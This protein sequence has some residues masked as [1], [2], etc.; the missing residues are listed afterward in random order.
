MSVDPFES[1]RAKLFAIAYRM[2]GS[3]ADAD[4]LVS[5]CWLRWSSADRSGVDNVGG[6]LA[7]VIVRLSIDLQKSA[8]MRR[9]QYVGP[10]LPEPLETALDDDPASRTAMAESVSSAFLLV[11]E[12][13][14]PAERA[15]L[16]LHD[17]FEFE[18]EE[19]GAMI[20]RSPEA[21]RQSLS[22]ARARLRERKPRFAAS[23]EQHMAVL[24]AFSLAIAT[25]DLDSLLALLS[26]DAAVISDSNGK[27][28]AAR[29]VVT[30]AERCARL[31]VGLA[32][33]AP[34]AALSA[35]VRELNGWP[36]LVLTRDGRA[37]SVIAIE[38]DGDRVFA[39]HAMRNPDKLARL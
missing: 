7:T 31:L 29:N 4:E 27:A 34:T 14:S 30:G 24:S 23:T 15:V 22:R 38:T 8:R 1:H 13:L 39:V 25:G 16:V 3:R 33:K 18:H 19:I 28:R 21:C 17:V 20:D 6:W 37:E 12:A 36:A 10:W 26:P 32:R 9:E 2:T 5:E 35:S 11:L